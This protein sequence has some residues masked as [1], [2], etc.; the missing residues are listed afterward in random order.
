[1]LFS[2]IMPVYRTEKELLNR[3]ISS[4]EKQIEK[5]WELK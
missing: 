1:M 5:D 3:A 2:I 4:I